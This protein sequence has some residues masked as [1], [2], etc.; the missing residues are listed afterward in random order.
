MAGKAK[1]LRFEEGLERLEA[2]AQQME[3]SE[4]PLE[5]LLARYE[6]G[7]KLAAELEKKLNEVKGR[8]QEVHAGKSG[9]PVFAETELVEQASMLDGLAN[10]EGAK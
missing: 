3:Q 6:E 2:L 5:E 1:A 4:L 7:V 8:L 9:E 10:G